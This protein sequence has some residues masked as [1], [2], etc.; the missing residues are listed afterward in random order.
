MTPATDPIREAM[1]EARRAQILDAAV[2]VFAEKGFHRATI[3]DIANAAGVADGT[4]YNYFKNKNDL[5]VAMVARL[6]EIN[7]FAGQAGHLA[8]GGDPEQILRFILRNRFELLERNRT[9][10][11]AL[12]P[13][14]INDPDLRSHFWQ[15]VAR[16]TLA[17]F[18]R[19]WQAQAEKGQIRPVNPRILVRLLIGMFLGVALLDMLEDPV[20][21]G[22]KE[23][24][25]D[26]SLDIILRGLLPREG[27]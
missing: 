16:P 19:V 26:D 12:I 18:E 11:Q 15:T 21:G 23:P 6:A 4:I 27:A 5:L 14:I 25:I 13:Q 7:Q 8:E 20:A 24:I 9:R 1:T 3:K 22:D 17:V 10:M 2:R